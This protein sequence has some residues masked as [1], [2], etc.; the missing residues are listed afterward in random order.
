M[1]VKK[2]D[3]DS[4]ADEAEEV[5]QQENVERQNLF[6]VFTHER[7][8]RNIDQVRMKISQFTGVCMR[9]KNI[10]ALAMENLLGAI[11]QDAANFKQ[12]QQSMQHAP[13][14]L[15]QQAAQEKMSGLDQTAPQVHQTPSSGIINLRFEECVFAS[16]AVQL[17]KSF[18]SQK[19]LIET[20][21]V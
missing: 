19:Q 1:P 10:T 14:R 4:S 16:K 21:V 3:S 12:M 11:E 8:L 15:R 13:N 2:R 7:E 5:K 20:F 18:L 9:C 17:L 6:V